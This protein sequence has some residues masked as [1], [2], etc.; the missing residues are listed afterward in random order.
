MPE[1][2]E[3]LPPQALPQEA[4]APRKSG[5]FSFLREALETLILA[6][7]LFA[8]INL[9]TARIRVEGASMLPTLRNGEFVLVNRL[10]YRFGEPQ[11]GDVIVFHYPKNPTQ[12]YVKRVI[13]LPGDVVEIERRQVKVN[14]EILDEVYIAEAP[15]YQVQTRVPPDTLFVLGDNRNNSSDS[16]SWGPVPMENLVGKAVFVYWPPPEWGSIQ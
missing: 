13:G 1:L 5:L 12:E 2:P 14:G 16:H 10:A 4:A 11:R 7:V 6:V 3:H 9:L 15:R 8:G